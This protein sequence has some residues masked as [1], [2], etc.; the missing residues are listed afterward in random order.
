[1]IRA[2]RNYMKVLKWKNLMAIGVQI[3]KKFKI[4]S[5]SIQV[6]FTIIVIFFKDMRPKS[7][8]GQ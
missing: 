8:Q 2:I 5:F 1:M 7:N 3:S 4:C 6:D